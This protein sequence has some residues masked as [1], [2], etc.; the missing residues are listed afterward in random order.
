M[1]E[2]AQDVLALVALPWGVQQVATVA[3]W[4]SSLITGDDLT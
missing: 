1:C 3:S 2:N 4:M